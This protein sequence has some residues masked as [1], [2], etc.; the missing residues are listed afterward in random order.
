MTFAFQLTHGTRRLALACLLAGV[1]AYAGLPV[2]APAQD[3]ELEALAAPYATAETLDILGQNIACLE[4]RL[5]A[6]R[7]ENAA[8]RG[9]VDV[10]ED[11]RGAVA[12][13]YRN[14]DGEVDR[15]GRYLGPATFVVS[16]DP[17]GGP[18]SLPLD[19]DRVLAM[20]GDADGCL[21]SLGLAGALVDGEPVETMFATGPCVLHLAADGTWSL[22]GAC[23]EGGFPPASAAAD[24]A[25]DGGPAEPAEAAATADKAEASDAAATAEPPRPVAPP[26]AFLWG[27]DGDAARF[28]DAQRG[29]ILLGFAGACFVSEAAPETARFGTAPPRFDRDTEA[30]LFLVA[31]GRNWDPTDTFPAAQLTARGTAPF[32]DC[33]LTLRD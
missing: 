16:G 1:A 21:A 27:R 6:V 15:E 13:A 25:D 28:G 33:R 32:F 17:R 23:A 8:L 7:E 3:C 20:C 5:E 26:A 29:R 9:R 22:S 24:A 11:A 12:A 2:P 30:D 14:R 10:L 31:A 18:T 19:H 4:R